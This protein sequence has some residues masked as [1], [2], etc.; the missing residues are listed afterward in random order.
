MTQQR[1][2]QSRGKNFPSGRHRG[3]VEVLYGVV[4]YILFVAG[5]SGFLLMRQSPSTLFPLPS[6]PCPAGWLTLQQHRPLPGPGGAK[7]PAG[8][9]VLPFLSASSGYNTALAH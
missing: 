9:P 8:G 3:D 2:T 4:T 6:T 7:S 1:N 5:V